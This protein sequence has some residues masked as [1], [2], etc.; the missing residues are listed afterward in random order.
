MLRVLKLF[1]FMAE[2]DGR[3]IDLGSLEAAVLVVSALMQILRAF[4]S[5]FCQRQLFTFRFLHIL[6]EIKKIFAISVPTTRR[7]YSSVEVLKN[8]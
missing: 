4:R 3:L 5:Y 1:V 2:I 8:F 7:R 6:E